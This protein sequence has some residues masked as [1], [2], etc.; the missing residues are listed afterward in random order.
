MPTS[1]RWRLWQ[2]ADRLLGHKATSNYRQLRE[3]QYRSSERLRGHSKAKLQAL[4][5]RAVRHVPFYR[6]RCQSGTMSKFPVL[7][8]AALQHHAVDLLAD[9]ANAPLRTLSSSGTTGERVSV[10]RDQA[11]QDMST[12]C[13]WRGDCWGADI[14]P[15]DNELVLLGHPLGLGARDTLRNR[16]SRLY[17][18]RILFRGFMFNARRARELHKLL[19]RLRP[20]ILSGYPTSMVAFTRF[21]R[22]LDLKPPP[23]AKVMPIAEQCDSSDA[24]ELRSFFCAPV[25]ER[26]GAHETGAIGHQC[27]HG[28]WHLHCEHIYLEVLK[29]DG[30]IANEGEGALLCTTLTNY[31]MPLI[32]YEIGDYAELVESECACGRGLPVFR[33]LEGRSGQFVFCPD[34]RWITSHGF[35]AP[36]RWFDIDCFRLVQDEPVGIRLM[37]AGAKLDTGDLERLRQAYNELHGGTLRVDFE[38]VDEIPH[39]P[40]GKRTR[41]QCLLPRPE[42]VTLNLDRTERRGL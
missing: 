37:L 25:L 40:S 3:S 39:L 35:L 34:G 13:A 10:K 4:I 42:N 41:V 28:A 19:W 38:F 12:A 9:N 32:R 22:E 15:W 14:A 26:Y 16:V 18:N 6:E 36:L 5:E 29:D 7:T 24:A 21:A 17:H 11:M 1:W 31:S 27:E 33:N 23:L 30:R 8:R 2:G 20:S